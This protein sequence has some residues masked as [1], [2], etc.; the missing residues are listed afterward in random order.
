E[1]FTQVRF[2]PALAAILI[3]LY[4]ITVITIPDVVEVPLLPA[5]LLLIIRFLAVRAAVYQIRISDGSHLHRFWRLLGA[6]LLLWLLADMVWLV[7]RIVTGAA[8]NIPSFSHL[9]RLSGYFAIIFAVTYY[10]RAST[11][12]EGFVREGL[13]VQIILLSI[14][15]IAWLSLLKPSL[16]QQS[17]SLPQIFWAYLTPFFD[18]FSLVLIARAV[19][20]LEFSSLV[21][22]PLYLMLSFLILGVTDVI[23]AYRL[24]IQVPEPSETVWIGRMVAISLVS[25]IASQPGIAVHSSRSA[26]SRP[27]SKWGSILN[28][29]MPIAFMLSAMVLIFF[30]WWISREPDWFGVAGAGLL[31]LLMFARQGTI[32]GQQ[33]MRQFKALVN[34][35]KDVAFICSSDGELRM[36]NPALDDLLASSSEADEDM[37]ISHFMS[38]EDPEPGDLSEI[39]ENASQSGWSGEVELIRSDGSRFPALVSLSPFEN[40]RWGGVFLAGTAHDLSPVR[41]REDQL[42]E[43]L[44]EVGAARLELSKLN[45]EL[46]QKVAD[47]TDELQDTIEDLARLNEELKTLDQLKS[48]FV[49]LVSHELRAPLTN[50]R[51]GIEL[52]LE[53]GPELSQKTHRSLELV[54]AEIYRLMYFVETI[55]D[56][57]ALEA[58]GVQFEM[59]PIELQECAQAARARLSPTDE[60]ERVQI[61]IAQDLAPVLA[62]QRALVSVFFHLMDNSLKYAPA[63]EVRVSAVEEGDRIIVAVRDEGPGIPEEE[64][65]KVFEMFHR[66]DPSDAREVYG[67]GLGLPMVRRFVEAM[68]GS[69]CI[70]SEAGMGTSIE[71]QLQ[72]A[73]RV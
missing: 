44:Q 32:M 23:D 3:A 10:P 14:L 72:K 31:T 66:L 55:L 12:Y 42:R 33:E 24:I 20:I 64:H 38:F 51:S 47:R 29:L 4:L 57:S 34:A 17:A 6:G 40:I 73:E 9:L 52:V 11:E 22:V 27:V 67:H 70:V 5:S 53:H 58:G 39:L 45:A 26:R 21:K 71:F 1:S 2:W 50:I 60:L 56:L 62:D 30:D 13:D 41:D 54:Q 18:I 25:F 46:E 36:A 37:H 8:P 61:R 49:A 43:A 19:L 59:L 7:Q 69:V 65:E 48:E 16:I 28:Y 35:T 68:D 63:G 15:S